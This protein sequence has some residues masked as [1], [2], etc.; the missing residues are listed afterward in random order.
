[1]RASSSSRF[2]G[3]AETTRAL[4]RASAVMRTSLRMPEFKSFRSL[5]ST[6][7][8]RS[9]AERWSLCCRLAWFA[10]RAAVPAGRGRPS[11]GPAARLAGAAAGRG[12]DR[13]HQNRGHV[14][15]QGVLQLD[16]ADLVDRG[17]G[18]RVEAADQI[19][20]LGHVARTRLDD[21]G[22]RAGVGGHA[23]RRPQ[24][25]RGLE[26][27]LDRVL[28]RDGRRV[29]E[30]EHLKL[31]IGIHRL[32]QPLDQIDHGLHVLGPA[33]DQHRV[34]LH[35]RRDADVA[36]P[37]QED[38]VVERS[39]QRGH[40]LAIDVAQRQH[41]DRRLGLGAEPLDLVDDLHH[42]L[43][44]LGVA[45]E[46]EHVEALEHFDLHRAEQPGVAFA[47]GRPFGGRRWQRRRGVLGCGDAGAAPSRG[48]KS[49]AAN[50]GLAGC[51]PVELRITSATCWMLARRPDFS[52]SRRTSLPA[53]LARAVEDL[54][55]SGKRADQRGRRLPHVTCEV[56]G[57]IVT[58]ISP[59]DSAKRY[60]FAGGRCAGIAESRLPK[61]LDK[62]RSICS[63]V[64]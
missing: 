36:L 32:I 24:L 57:S 10:C 6:V 30:V 47:L 54:D 50:G 23:H 53:G 49:M 52:G 39:H 60:C 56:A 19:G 29:L 42:L 59:P 62:A 35:H 16:D 7:R 37:R 11:A 13:L 31:R 43:H 20:H 34:G 3:G 17:A 9:M 44:V 51:G 58:S 22:V 15:R 38:L 27:L 48:W 41:F 64:A 25:R 63:A 45:A 12:A 2:S 61:M 55:Q 28:G 40:R 33:D 46:H 21:Q 4:A 14:L 1:M 8:K 5:A 18:G 26:E